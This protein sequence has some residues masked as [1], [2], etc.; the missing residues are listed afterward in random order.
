MLVLHLTLP[1]I[2]EPPEDI[3][4]SRYGLGRLSVPMPPGDSSNDHVLHQVYNTHVDNMFFP[5]HSLLGL[6]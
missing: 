1:S 5:L 2:S 6:T 4:P 3:P